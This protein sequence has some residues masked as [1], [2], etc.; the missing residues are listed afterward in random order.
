MVVVVGYPKGVV[1]RDGVVD[2]VRLEPE[3]RQLGML[4]EQTHQAAADLA[5]DRDDEG[6]AA[7]DGEFQKLPPMGYLAQ[8]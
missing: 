1:R 7:L 3:K 4:R 2:G 8:A 6:V 5:A